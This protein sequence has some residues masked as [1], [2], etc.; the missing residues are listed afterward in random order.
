MSQNILIALIGAAGAVIGSI[1]T[2]AAQFAQNYLDKKK[3]ERL[4]QPQTDLLKEMLNHP[5]HVWRKLDT[6]MHVIGADEET[7][8]RLL[9]KCNARASE[10]GKA[11][12]ALRSR[13]P[14]PGE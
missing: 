12:W 11:I 8:K 5:D 6:L 4:E 3:L 14:L 2:I 1:A 13:A 9:L 7:T 10:D